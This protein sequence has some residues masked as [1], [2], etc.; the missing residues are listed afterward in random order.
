MRLWS[1]FVDLVLVVLERGKQRHSQ[2]GAVWKQ[3][4]CK[5]IVECRRSERDH[6]KAGVNSNL[7][8]ND[9]TLAAIAVNSRN[10]SVAKQRS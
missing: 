10:P 4:K 3:S 2:W 1:L 7:T 8:I 6:V 5:R 9:G